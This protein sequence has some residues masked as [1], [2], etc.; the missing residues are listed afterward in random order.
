MLKLPFI[1]NFPITQ[2]FGEN[3]AVFYKAEGLLGHQGI[4]YA[5]PIGTA[6]VAP[7]DG[8]VIYIST[9]IQRGEGVTIMSDEIYKYNNQNCRLSCVHWHL[10][11]Q[12]IKVKVGD[13]VKTGDLIALSGNTGQT[14]GPHLHFSVSPLSPDAFRHELALGNG[15]KGCIDPFPYL[16]LP[17]STIP[18]IN[19]SFSHTWNI[20]IQK[21]KDFQSS[22]NLVVD[23]IVGPKTQQ[24]IDSLI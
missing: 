10:K 21:I 13:K 12:S 11:D 16:E 7:C 9:D 23:G 22:H 4:D 15:Y 3:K 18:F 17:T 8:L 5:M 1:G 2:K 6:I 14:T 24:V 20:P 19:V